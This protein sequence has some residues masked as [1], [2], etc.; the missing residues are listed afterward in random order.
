M[1]WF[2]NSN[3][4][5]MAS[6]DDFEEVQKLTEA[7]NCDVFKSQEIEDILVLCKG[8]EKYAFDFF[9]PEPL[10]SDPAPCNIDSV[11]MFASAPGKAY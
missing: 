5:S 7:L 10:I 4:S 3:A 8:Y 1:T 9:Y 2:K 11:V 6:E